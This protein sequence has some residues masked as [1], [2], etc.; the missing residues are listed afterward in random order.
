[1][2]ITGRITGVQPTQ[3]GGYQGRNGYIYTF[4]MA[5]DGPNGQI[6]GE[7]G[8]KSQQYPLTVG[9]EITVDVKQDGQYGNKF[10][11]VNP[12]FQ[13]GGNQPQQTQPAQRQTPSKQEP[14]WD[15]IA[16]GKVRHGV[17]CAAI[18]SNQ[19]ECKTPEAVAFWTAIIMG[20]GDAEVKPKSPEPWDEPQPEDTTDYSQDD[21]DDPPF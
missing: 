8:S 21:Q 5:I 2:Q 10:K 4:D 6:V 11:S 19:I 9:D 16:E 12:K 14:D 7:I 3:R 18:Q 17:I 13:G 1:M 15:A 20:K